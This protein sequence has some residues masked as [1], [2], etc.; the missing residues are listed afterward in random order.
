M[1]FEDELFL[2]DDADIFDIINFGF[3]RQYYQREDHFNSM[4]DMSFFRRFR[5]TKPVVLRL[6]EELEDVLEFPNDL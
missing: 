2:E 1:E 6:I 4:D 5:L 3:P